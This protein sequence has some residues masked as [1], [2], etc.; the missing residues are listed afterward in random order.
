MIGIVSNLF[1][2]LLLLLNSTLV[3]KQ[4]CNFCLPPF[5]L[6]CNFGKQNTCGNVSKISVSLV[7]YWQ[8]GLQSTDCSH[9][10]DLLTFST[11]CYRAVIGEFRSDLSILVT[12]KTD[13]NFGNVVS[14]VF[15]FPKSRIKENGG[16]KIA[17]N[18]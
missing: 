17:H 5:S 2:V 9:Q 7:C 16:I 6:I 11:S 15:C 3:W 12:R 18:R 1:S 4:A 13:G 14:A 10:C 8:I